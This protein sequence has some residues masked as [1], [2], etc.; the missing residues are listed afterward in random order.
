MATAHLPESTL[1]FTAVLAADEPALAAARAALVAEWGEIVLASPAYPFHYTSYYEREAGARILRAFLAFAAPF[2]REEL[3]DRKL[4]S[5]AIEKIL[6]A[7]IGGELPRPVNLDPGY[8]ALDKLVLASC[9]DFSH[10]LYLRDGVYAEITL[11][12]RGGKW[13]HFPW[14]FP[15]YASGDY[16]EFFGQMRDCLRR[17]RGQ[18]SPLTRQVW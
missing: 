13:T 5:N 14:T 15:D 10:R 11:S 17:R 18:A 12:Y 4:R 3:P 6:R 9:K 2:A 1:F 8:L 7:E 16:D